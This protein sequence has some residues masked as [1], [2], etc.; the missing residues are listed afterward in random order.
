MAGTK[1][2]FYTMPSQR[3]TPESAITA[4]KNHYGKEPMS[5][6][7]TLLQWFNWCD[8]PM[9][10]FTEMAKLL[11]TDHGQIFARA[12]SRG[13][14][15]RYKITPIFNLREPGLRFY[16]VEAVLKYGNESTAEVEFKFPR[17]A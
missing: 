10:S 14:W 3:K 16:I 4:V 11:R 13:R 5:E 2:T 6:Y 8:K 9:T 7:F 1:V 15:A 17:N 12:G